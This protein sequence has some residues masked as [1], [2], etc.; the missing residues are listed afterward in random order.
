MADQIIEIPGIGNVAFPETMSMDELNLAVQ[1]I[2]SKQAQ[3]T[4]F[5]SMD[6]SIPSEETFLPRVDQSIPTDQ[7]LAPTSQSPQMPFSQQIMRKAAQIPQNIVG[8]AEAMASLG[9]GM[10]STLGGTV[11]GIAKS[12][13]TGEPAEQIAERIQRGLTYT[14][15]T[16]AGQRIT[17][18]VAG[19]LGIFEGLPPYAPVPSKFG[20]RK[21]TRVPTQ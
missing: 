1:D 12:P 11:A 7:N 13:F 3:Q 18:D 19:A 9:T 15:R 17:Q 21:P 8:S 14:P 20:I 10:L 2:I 4:D 6:Q 16:E 5:A